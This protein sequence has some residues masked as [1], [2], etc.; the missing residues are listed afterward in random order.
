MA[1]TTIDPLAD[2]LVYSA[3]L[4][5]SWQVF[6]SVPSNNELLNL[7]QHNSHVLDTVLAID[8]PAHEFDSGDAQET[9]YLRHL[10]NKLNLLL[11]WTACLMQQSQ[12]LPQRL[13]IKLSR[14]G[15]AI[16]TDKNISEGALL[17]VECFPADY[18]PQALKLFGSVQPSQ[19]GGEIIL[20]FMEVSEH[21]GDLLDK[22]IFRWHRRSVALS[23]E[24]RANDSGA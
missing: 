24:H 7:R 13:P 1:Q 12:H 14:R 22:F 2:G 16:A 10:D 20:A 23:R 15:M 19:T 4:P 9:Q 17:I 18:F 5:V 11:H 3:E 21:V 6:P 8:D